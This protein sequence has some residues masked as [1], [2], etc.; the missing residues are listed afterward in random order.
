MPGRRLCSSIDW[1]EGEKKD[2]ERELQQ[3]LVGMRDLR[4][5][6]RE[7]ARASV[8]SDFIPAPIQ[9]ARSQPSISD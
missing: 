4:E 5:R 6:E 3:L 9:P 7:R 2:R 8:S 1:I